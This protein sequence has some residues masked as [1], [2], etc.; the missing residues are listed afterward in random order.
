[1]G[2][3]AA[4]SLGYQAMRHREL[5]MTYAEVPRDEAP[6]VTWIWGRPGVGK[7]AELASLLEQRDARS[8]VYY[9][10]SDD[11]WWQGYDRH[12]IIVLR[13]FESPQKLPLRIL[14]GAGPLKVETKGGFREMVAKEMF[15][16]TEKHPAIVCDGDQRILRKIDRIV[17]CAAK[18]QESPQKSGGN[19]GPLKKRGKWA[20]SLAAAEV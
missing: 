7:G 12:E 2:E 14:F 9:K 15:V 3:D 4:M 20:A 6:V 5:I 11:K 1:M 10:R 17:D 13:S 18:A 19:I 16:L 8:R